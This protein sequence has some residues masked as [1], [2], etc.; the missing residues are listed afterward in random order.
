M[1]IAIDLQACQTASRFRGI[2]RYA[3]SF[4][5]A[6]I[7]NRGEHEIFIVLCAILPEAIT[8]IREILAPILPPE[9]IVV[10]DGPKL[11]YGADPD[12]PARQEAGQI[13]REAFIKALHPDITLITS[14]FEGDDVPMLSVRRF[15]ASTP[16]AVILYDLI[17]L[18]YQERYL[19]PNPLGKQFYLKKIDYLKQ[20]S[21]LLS[22]SSSSRQEA[23]DYLDIP[24]DQVINMSSAADPHFYPQILSS[25]EQKRLLKPYHI[26]RPFVMYTG[27]GDSRKNIEGLIRAYALLDEP[28]RLSHQLVI[29]C[30]L[31]APEIKRLGNLAQ[32]HGLPK[33]DV[34]FT[35]FVPEEDLVGLYN[36]CKLFVFPSMH[37]GFGLPALE[38]MSCKKAVLVSNCSSLPE[39][40]GRDDMLFDPKDDRDIAN[41]IQAVLQNPVRQ[42]ELEEYGFLQAQNFSWDKS[43]RIALL[44]MQETVNQLRAS[45][46][47]SSNLVPMESRRLKLAYVSPLPDEHSGIASYSAELLPYLNAYYEIDV[48]TRQAQVTDPW[49]TEHCKLV[50][51]EQFVQQA[52]SYDRVL[53]HFGNS[54]FHEHMFALSKQVPGVVVQHD[55]FISNLIQDL[56][57][58]AG[59]QNN[60]LRQLYNSHGYGAL[61][62]GLKNPDPALAAWTYPVNREV[63][64]DAYG[65][66]FH[67]PSSLRQLVNLYGPRA[68]QA[69][70]VI[71]HLRIP[72]KS[73]SKQAARER[74][75]IAPDAFL[76]CSFGLVSKTKAN[77]RLLK[78][79]IR[80]ALMKDERCQIY[81]VGECSEESYQKEIQ[82]LI[83]DAR[84]KGRVHITGWVDD[85]G[86]QTYLEAADMAVQLRTLSRGETSGTIL[87]CLN[88]SLP[89]VIN[90]S[91]TMQDFSPEV[92]WKLEEDYSDGQLIEALEALYQNHEQRETLGS[93][94]KIYLDHHHDP[95][96]CA[97]QYYETIEHFYRNSAS[98]VVDLLSS[99]SHK[100]PLDSSPGLLAEV[101]TAFANTFTSPFQSKQL[102]IDITALIDDLSATPLNLKF[103]LNGWLLQTHPKILLEPIYCRDGR[104]YYARQ[105]CLT[106]LGAPAGLLVDEPVQI[107]PGDVLVVLGSPQALLPITPEFDL[108]K[109]HGNRALYLDW[110]HGEL[111]LAPD[112]F[113]GQI[114]AN[115][116]AENTVQSISQESSRSLTTLPERALTSGN[117][118]TVF[119]ASFWAWVNGAALTE[120]ELT[121]LYENTLSALLHWMDDQRLD[122]PVT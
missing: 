53:Y 108:F 4:T 92:V 11:G 80:S 64:Q 77:T 91:G 76:V 26:D 25:F 97:K 17:P 86:F 102:L 50:N 49:I 79:F 12:D 43:A 14:L 81:F 78:A 44:A 119:D 31:S 117:I 110:E 60:W 71:P 87:D 48:I 9:N 90:A 103:L 23:I 51:P 59:T 13:L 115:M 1:R 42:K 52:S 2:G 41:K 73:F 30:S 121:T 107:T 83:D 66:I 85:Q 105:F 8:Q 58:L 63:L 33:S 114:L 61:W 5:Q 111:S 46:Q 113:H 15:D 10:F 24:A 116:L 20:A 27:G 3:M 72:K 55:F 70:V 35:N 28:L 16:V 47:A 65:V 94:G 29:V 96:Y 104:A 38:A 19:D 122:L 56:D 37:E 75:G 21:L 98:N 84:L 36:C 93:L 34:V 88:H 39:V 54:T 120:G 106:L 57:W 68:A 67:S 109:S 18:I 112:C 95:S 69:A 62:M 6:L 22:I 99:I 74:L 40:V 101:S 82:D 89:T 118:K 100:L 32:E 45:E 7:R